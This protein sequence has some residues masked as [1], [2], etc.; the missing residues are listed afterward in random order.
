[1]FERIK[2]NSDKRKEKQAPIRAKSIALFNDLVNELMTHM[3][4]CCE[5]CENVSKNSSYQEEFSKLN[6]QFE[7]LKKDYSNLSVSELSELI[8]EAKRTELILE[9]KKISDL[10]IKMLKKIGN[11]QE[12]FSLEEKLLD[13][14]K[15]AAKFN[16]LQAKGVDHE[17]YYYVAAGHLVNEAKEDKTIDIDT[18]TLLKHYLSFSKAGRQAKHSGDKFASSFDRLKD[19]LNDLRNE[20]ITFAELKNCCEDAKTPPELRTNAL[21]LKELVDAVTSPE[22]KLNLDVNLYEE[23]LLSYTTILKENKDA[24][25]KLST[26]SSTLNES[27][28]NQVSQMVDRV[29][30]TGYL[31]SGIQTNFDNDLKTAET[32]VQKNLDIIRA[33]FDVLDKIMIRSQLQS[34]ELVRLLLESKTP[35]PQVQQREVNVH[36]IANLNQWFRIAQSKLH[37]IAD[38]KSLKKFLKTQSKSLFSG[39]QERLQQIGIKELTEKDFNRIIKQAA[40]R[41]NLPE[42]I[43]NNLS[44]TQK[45]SGTRTMFQKSNTFEKINALN[46]M[47]K[48]FTFDSTNMAKEKNELANSL[49]SLGISTDLLTKMYDS[50]KEERLVKLEK[51][52]SD[53]HISITVTPAEVSAGAGAGHVDTPETEHTPDLHSLDLPESRSR[54]RSLSVSSVSSVDSDSEDDKTIEAKAP[55]ASPAQHRVKIHGRSLSTGARTTISPKNPGKTVEAESPAAGPAQHRVKMH[56][57]LSTGTETTV[58]K[59]AT[60]F[61]TKPTHERPQSAPSAR[62]TP[63][64]KD[65]KN[66]DEPQRK[67]SFDKRG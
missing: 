9:A 47:V 29:M 58:T 36:K 20:P 16:G 24:E 32:T 3:E 37:N 57:K 34:G 61:A 5:A 18:V 46:L 49:A 30:T 40:Y 8:L 43:R 38:A 33:S 21:K 59:G 17:S 60:F 22:S 48:A 50:L 12:R 15:F 31:H 10:F 52:E 42:A 56:R 11:A 66:T 45:I 65:A 67:S 27:M 26:V 25:A 63:N 28:S 55:A 54:S 13:I 14:P 64:N 6:T 19:L 2:T 7:K 44:P 51:K 53:P 62:P 4:H 39:L 41:A 1:M 35:A 23:K